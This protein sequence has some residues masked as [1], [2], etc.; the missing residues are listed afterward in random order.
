MACAE[1]CTCAWLQTSV[2]AEITEV[3]RVQKQNVFGWCGITGVGRPHVSMAAIHR[4]CRFKGMGKSVHENSCRLMLS[5]R[6]EPLL[7]S[8]EL[9]PKTALLLLSGDGGD[10]LV[11]VQATPEG[12]DVRLQLVFLPAGLLPG[13]FRLRQ[14]LQHLLRG[15]CEGSQAHSARNVEVCLFLLPR[16]LADLT[17]HGT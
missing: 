3:S 16:M 7:C 10:V 9:L 6:V 15:L 1:S 11:R 5:F 8:V 2:C 4:L 17:G 14:L 13:S 12:D